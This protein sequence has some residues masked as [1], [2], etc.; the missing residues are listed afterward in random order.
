MHPADITLNAYVD[1]DLPASDSDAVRRHLTGC[2]SCRRLVADLEAVV[3]HAGRLGSIEPPVETWARIARQRAL[4]G[5]SRGR[6][7]VLPGWLATAA[8][9]VLA[10]AAGLQ[11]AAWRFAHEAPH[12]SRHA[13]ALAPEW[14]ETEAIYENAIAGLQEGAASIETALGPSLGAEWRNNLTALNAAIADSRAALARNPD[15]AVAR[16]SLFD[17]LSTKAAVLQTATEIVAQG[18]NQRGN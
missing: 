10:T 12:P 18:S 13:D 1:G 17:G 9:L 14:R 4:E 8:L 5:V 16:H 2:E 6:T 7:P 15:D 11:L 3:R